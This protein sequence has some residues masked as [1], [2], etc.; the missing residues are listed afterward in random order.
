MRLYQ[1]DRDRETET[2]RQRDRAHQSSEKIND[3]AGVGGG[4]LNLLAVAGFKQNDINA[5]AD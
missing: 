3:Q 2:Q 4:V 5:V 1:G